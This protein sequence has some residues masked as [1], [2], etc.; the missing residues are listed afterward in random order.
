MARKLVNLRLFNDEEGRINLSLADA[1]GGIL[2]VEEELV[3][4]ESP[5]AGARVLGIPSTRMAEQLG[6]RLIQNIVMVG[7]F[8]QQID[9][10]TIVETDATSVELLPMND[11]APIRVVCLACPS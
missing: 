3:H 1:A 10:G 9:I 4:V 8:T 5:P 11:P 6:R 7:F 2:L